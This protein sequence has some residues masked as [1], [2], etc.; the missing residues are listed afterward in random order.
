MYARGRE[1]EMQG[2][3]YANGGREFDPGRFHFEEGEGGR[4]YV[5]LGY[6]PRLVLFF[7]FYAPGYS[8][9]AVR[10]RGRE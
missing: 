8:N 10:T 3:L 9:H 6:T 1:I 5:P 7:F 4:V 2:R